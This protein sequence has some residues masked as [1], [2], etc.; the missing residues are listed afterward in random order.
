[1]NKKIDVKFNQTAKHIHEIYIN[2]Y[3]AGLIKLLSY[4][5]PYEPLSYMKEDWRVF[6]WGYYKDFQLDCRSLGI[7]EDR[8][9]CNITLDDMKAKL[10][11]WLETKQ[12]IVL[13]KKHFEAKG[14][15]FAHCSDGQIYTIDTDYQDKFTEHFY[16]RAG[17]LLFTNIQELKE[18]A[19][20][21]VEYTKVNYPSFPEVLELDYVMNSPIFNTKYYDSLTKEI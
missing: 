9:G 19:E 4:N 6:F 5:K 15:V 20:K 7:W 21:L 10:V 2:G 1:M 13:P 12:D 16:L 18:R 14:Y 17:D 3:K 11:E 8:C